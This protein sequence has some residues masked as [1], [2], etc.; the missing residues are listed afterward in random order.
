MFAI[1]LLCAFLPFG[2]LVLVSYNQVATFFNQRNQRQLRELAKVFG[3]DV[4]EKLS[5]LESE[6]LVIAS[7][8]RASEQLPSE[9]SLKN[10][11]SNTNEQ[12]NAV[13]VITSSGRQHRLF[14]QIERLPNLSASDRR[15]LVTG[16]P[17][18]SVG[19]AAAGHP[20]R[21]FMSVSMDPRQ[22]RSGIL[23][24]EINHA[25]LWG[26]GNSRVLRSYV[27]P[28]VQDQTGSMLMC[29]ESDVSSFPDTLREKMRRSALGD[30]EWTHQ[31]QDYLASYWTIP[32][33]FRFQ[34]P[35]WTVIL[36][37]SKEAA[38]AS[39]GELQSTFLLG[40]LVSGG[41]SI[42]LAI[43]QIRKRLVP[44][45]KLQEGTQR[46]AQQDFGFK[47]NVRSNDEFEELANSVNTMAS[48]LGQQFHALSTKA[49][50][51]RAV[52][53]LLD[54]GKIVETILNRLLEI[55]P[56]NSASLTLLN[57]DDRQPN[58]V[59]I[60]TGKNGLKSEDAGSV[61]QTHEIHPPNG[62]HKKNSA[63]SGQMLRAEIRKENDPIALRVA[64]AKIPLVFDE[65]EA[66][67][68][69]LEF[70]GGNGFRSIMAA[71]LIVKDDALGV[72]AF[73]SSESR[74]FTDQ[75][76]DFLRGLTSQAAIAIYNSQ[77]FEHTKQQAV[78]L[79]KLNKAKDEFLSVMSHE[80]R[81]PLNVILGYQRMIQEKMLGDINADQARAID[82]IGRHSNDLLAMIENIMEATNIEAGAVVI[83][84]QH[85][86]LVNFFEDL[87]SHNVLPREKDLSLGWHYSADLPALKTDESKLKRILQ[88]LIENALK[89]T[90]EGHVDVSAH[91]LQEQEAVAF[92][93][94]DTGIGIPEESQSAIFEM[95]R[96]LDSSKTREYGGAGLG[97]YS[98]K[99]LCALLGATI[100]V[101]SQAGRGTT[102]T[103]SLPATNEQTAKRVA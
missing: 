10:I 22:L 51:D 31:G 83:E 73:Y 9:A 103:V 43:F 95:F 46:I 88:N 78:E 42:L 97:L 65:F 87:K 25:Y 86:D 54:T 36:K 7:T 40:I 91:Y 4:F 49:E 29:S 77:L 68:L 33:Q 102:F 63:A 45:E 34:N 93:V 50:I 60:L 61:R 85:V 74:R 27:Q 30:F 100:N 39:I 6:L 67:A 44:V 84:N 75:T 70:M 82:T 80:L 64:E 17:L 90:A 20:M 89:F 37:T 79:E 13:S 53:S 66:E 11:R 52:L 72:L 5:L 38:F 81:T 18:L 28:C 55:F 3:I 12:W 8:V 23:T 57:S 21:I 32:L 59:F 26:I 35:G 62:D 24:G 94:A 2:G 101:D 99:K 1:F 47:V 71:P 98:V 16:K 48:H 14:G 56:C 15:R 76:V 96:Q 19:S 69:N 58:R 92:K 41:L